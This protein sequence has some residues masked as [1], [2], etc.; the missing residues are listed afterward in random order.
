VQ[1]LI[2]DYRRLVVAE[3]SVSHLRESLALF[4][5]VAQVTIGARG[6]CPV[7]SVAGDSTMLTSSTAAKFDEYLAEFLGHA[8]NNGVFPKRRKAELVQSQDLAY[9]A[10]VALILPGFLERVS[11]AMDGA[12]FS[13]LLDVGMCVFH[14]AYFELVPEMDPQMRE[15]RSRILDAFLQFSRTLA[16]DADRYVLIALVADARACTEEAGVFYE[17][18]VEAADPSSHDFLSILQ[19]AWGH[20]VE[21]GRFA[22]AMLLLMQNAGRIPKKSYDEFQEMVTMTVR[23]KRKRLIAGSAR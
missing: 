21:H 10:I 13:L 9:R 5:R 2:D 4:E 6:D 11:D 19:S 14:Q 15:E 18:A 17:H 12:R 23:E 1:T 22:D 16:S 3:P 20:H 7:L 8:G